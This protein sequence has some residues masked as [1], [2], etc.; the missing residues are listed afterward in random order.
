MR[1]RSLGRRTRCIDGRIMRHDP[2]PD[3][4]SLETDI[5]KCPDCDGKGCEVEELPTISEPDAPGA[6][7]GD[8]W[9]GHSEK[10]SMGTHRWDGEK[11]EVLPS[12]V[13]TLLILLAKAREERDRLRATLMMIAGWKHDTLGTRTGVEGKSTED[14]DRGTRMAFYRCADA[15]SKALNPE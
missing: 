9:F 2:Q 11:W 15:A 8:I 5:G 1:D 3:D 14:F 6:F 13:E 7:K 4:P 12:E 10:R